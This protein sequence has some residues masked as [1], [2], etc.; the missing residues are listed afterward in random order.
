[1]ILLFMLPGT[2][3]HHLTQLLVEFKSHEQKF[4]PRVAGAVFLLISAF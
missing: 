1:M 3:M 4:L 2:G